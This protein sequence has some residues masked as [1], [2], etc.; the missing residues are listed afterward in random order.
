M[1]RS[2]VG[3]RSCSHWLLL[4]VVP[5]FAG[6]HGWSDAPEGA[7]LGGPHGTVLR[8]ETRTHTRVPL[9]NVEVRGDSLYGETPSCH[10]SLALGS[11]PGRSWCS[12]VAIAR[13]DVLRTE[14]RVP[15]PYR[16]NVAILVFGLLWCAV[17]VACIE[18]LSE[19]RA[20]SPAR[21]P[22]RR[23]GMSPDEHKP[24]RGRGRAGTDPLQAGNVGA[25]QHAQ[26][27]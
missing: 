22:S 5:L 6:C 11:S 26:A 19:A 17:M 20:G 23:T 25:S 7:A 12:G 9:E 15:A 16:T 4:A 1:R 24:P 8:I 10:W 14:V 3:P 18:L 21:T 13:A 27:P 2:T